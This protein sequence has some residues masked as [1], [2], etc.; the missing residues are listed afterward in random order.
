[1]KITVEI[2]EDGTST[3]DVNGIKGTKCTEYTDVLIKA[4]GGDVIS[5]EK[6]PEYHDKATDTMKTGG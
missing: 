4:L 6:K 2:L 5:D 1:M 3:I